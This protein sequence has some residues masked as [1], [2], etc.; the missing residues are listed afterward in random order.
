VEK[1]LEAL[2][3]T[4]TPD[5]GVAAQVLTYGDVRELLRRLRR[6][7]G[8]IRAL[9]RDVDAVMHRNRWDQDWPSLLGPVAHRVAREVLLNEE[10]FPA[11]RASDSSRERLGLNFVTVML[12]R[13][14]LEPRDTEQAVRDAS[15]PDEFARDLLALWDILSDP[16]EMREEQKDREPNAYTLGNPNAYDHKLAVREVYKQPGGAVFWTEGAARKALMQGRNGMYLPEEWFPNAGPIPGAVY[17][18]SVDPDQVTTKRDSVGAMRL[19]APAL[20]TGKVE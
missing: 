14:G 19:K 7:K 20:I 15:I 8:E 9:V 10:D 13:A 6:R 3:S 11:P 12:D 16:D 4:K 5:D 17:G 1:K 18:L 2:A